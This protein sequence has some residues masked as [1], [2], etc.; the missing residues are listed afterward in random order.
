MVP[1][2]MRQTEPIYIQKFSC[3]ISLCQDYSRIRPFMQLNVRI[4]KLCVN[5]QANNKYKRINLIYD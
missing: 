3:K 1:Y 5:R 4:F 2:S